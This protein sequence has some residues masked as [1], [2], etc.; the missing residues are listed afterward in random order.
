MSITLADCISYLA[1]YS[2][3]TV[4]ILLF[5]RCSYQ[6]VYPPHASVY[7]KNQFALFAS[8]SLSC[9]IILFIYYYLLKPLIDFFPINKTWSDILLIFCFIVINIFSK[10]VYEKFFRDSKSV[11]TPS[12]VEYLWITIT[13]Y[14]IGVLKPITLGMISL[15][16]PLAIIAGRFFWLD[17]DFST[18]KK[19]FEIDHDNLKKTSMLLLGGLLL[20]ELI[21]FLGK[22]PSCMEIYL[23]LFYG[24][25]LFLIS[26]VTRKL[27]K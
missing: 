5:I 2:I 4:V 11:Y 19:L 18:L 9:I 1:C 13:A 15:L 25:V 3:S 20:I 7:M 12:D 16:V 26:L 27:T 17:T 8:T 22:L 6:I 10:Y 21:M 14:I 24:I 23:S